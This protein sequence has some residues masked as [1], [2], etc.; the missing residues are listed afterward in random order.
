MSGALLPLAT[1]HALTRQATTMTTLPSPEREQPIPRSRAPRSV[2]YGTGTF[3]E[4][5]VIIGI[6]ERFTT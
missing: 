4:E 6:L 2:E 1:S 3:S 5:S